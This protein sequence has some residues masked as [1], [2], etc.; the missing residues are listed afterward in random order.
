MSAPSFPSTKPNCPRCKSERIASKVEA[1][2]G[3]A[4]V[5]V[6]CS[7]CGAIISWS[8]HPTGRG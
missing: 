5:L 8:Q 1:Y 6:Y 4:G 7:E 2:D 3:R